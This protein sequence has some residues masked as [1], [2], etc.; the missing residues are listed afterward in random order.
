MTSNL[1]LDQ[2]IPCGDCGIELS[3]FQ[4]NHSTGRCSA[5]EERS[6][7]SA[8]ASDFDPVREAQVILAKRELAKRHIIP[9]VELMQPAYSAG[10]VHKQIAKRLELFSLQVAHKLSPRLAIFMP[11]RHGKS[12]LASKHFPAWHLGHFPTHEV[13]SSSYSGSLALGFSRAVKEAIKDPT[14]HNIFDTQ[15]HPEIQAS[16]G[17]MTTDGGGFTPAGVGGAITGKGAHIAIIDDP[18]KNREEAESQV[19][20]QSIKDWYTST[21]Y[22]RLAPGG[23]VLLILT[24]WHDDDLAG[25]LLE[26]DRKGE[27]DKWEVIKYPAI[28]TQDEEYRKKGEALHPVRYPVEALKRIQRAV[29]PRDWPA[30]YQ[31]DPV[32]DEGAYFD[33][34]M[35]KYYSDVELPPMERMTFYTCWDLAIGKSEANDF[36]VGATFGIDERDRIFLVDIQRGRWDGYEIVEKILD[37]QVAWRSEITGIERGQISM[38][39]GPFLQQRITERRVYDLNLEALNPGRR[40]KEARARPLQ[41]LMRQGR[42]FFPQNA[43]WFQDLYNE[44]LRFPSGIHDDIVDACAWFGQLLTSLVTPAP[45]KEPVKKSWRDNL[46]RFR[47]GGGSGSFM[48]S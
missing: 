23:G 19:V 44:F 2:F 1:A 34:S 27:G 8:N 32:A 9:Y 7:E 39:L 47:S 16:D 3:I 35:F 11:P 17:W 40:D 13:I 41:G 33:K 30:L 21:L 37:V 36:T 25:W 29:G 15:L 18:V 43:P 46:S 6:K 5:C 20:R 14:Y 26:Q 24:R 22:T 12:Q 42:V 48:S 31:Q 45:E 4:L 28:A 10:W 38:A